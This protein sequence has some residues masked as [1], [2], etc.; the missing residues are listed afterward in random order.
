MSV[1]CKDFVVFF[2]FN[3]GGKDDIVKLIVLGKSI[4]DKSY[5]TFLYFARA[6]Y[7][8]RTV[9]AFRRFKLDCI[10]DLFLMV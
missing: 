10:A 4:R 9:L 6:K 3:C 2:F 7:G 1:F 5:L 8:Q